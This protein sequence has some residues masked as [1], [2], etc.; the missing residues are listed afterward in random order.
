[1]S[2]AL[3]FDAATFATVAMVVM[4][5]FVML[6]NVHDVCG[7]EWHAD[8]YIV[9]A[10][11]SIRLI[12]VLVFVFYVFT[13]E[14]KPM[15][16]KMQIDEK[17]MRGIMVAVFF[18]CAAVNIAADTSDGLTELDTVCFDMSKAKQSTAAWNDHAVQALCSGGVNSTCTIQTTSDLGDLYNNPDHLRNPQKHCHSS[19]LAMLKRANPAQDISINP[20]LHRC[21]LWQAD[22]CELMFGLSIAVIEIVAITAVVVFAALSTR[23]RQTTTST[24]QPEKAVNSTLSSQP[25]SQPESGW[26]QPRASAGEWSMR[27]R[28]TKKPYAYSRLE[29]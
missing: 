7:S 26:M 17:L 2:T 15:V 22:K 21:L 19:L 1:M 5:R 4:T 20:D 25:E 29:L 16:D 9:Y 13:T 27:K 14:V 24:G 18:V 12:T 28:S 23:A 10:V 11:E 8:L 6:T 3:V